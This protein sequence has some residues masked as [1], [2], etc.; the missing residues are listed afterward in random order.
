M[1]ISPQPSLTH[2]IN[3]NK[4]ERGDLPNSAISLGRLVTRGLCNYKHTWS[5]RSIA[6]TVFMLAAVFD[7]D[8]IKPQEEYFLHT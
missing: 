4:L 6:I 3:F 5:C 1:L 7:S 2:H 8:S